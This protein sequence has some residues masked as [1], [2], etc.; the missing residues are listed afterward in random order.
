ME[1]GKPAYG[2]Y[3]PKSLPFITELSAAPLFSDGKVVGAVE[4]LRKT[5]QRERVLDFASSLIKCLSS[6]Q[7]LSAVCR[8]LHEGLKYDRVRLYSVGPEDKGLRGVMFAGNHPKVTEETFRT[9]VGRVPESVGTRWMNAGRAGLLRLGEK[10]PIR[11]SLGYWDCPLDK[12]EF[13]REVDPNDDLEFGDVKEIIVVPFEAEKDHYLFFVDSKYRGEGTGTF[14]HDDLQAVSMLAKLADAALVA[15]VS[16]R[17]RFIM[18]VV[19]EVTC[20]PIHELANLLQ[21]NQF[22]DDVILPFEK[23]LDIA[24][25][26][27]SRTGSPA[28]LACVWQTLD[29]AIRCLRAPGC[30]RATGSLELRRSVEPLTLKVV[31]LKEKY[32][33]ALAQLADLD[34]KMAEGW[35]VL[36]QTDKESS[37]WLEAFMAIRDIIV[38]FRTQANVSQNIGLLAEGIRSVMRSDSELEARQLERKN[39]VDLVKLAVETTKRHAVKHAVSVSF[40]GTVEPLWALLLGGPVVMAMLA[41]LDNAITA[42]GKTAS[43]SVDIGFAEDH[44]HVTVIIANNGNRIPLEHIPHVGK[45]PFTTKEPGQGTGLGLVFAYHWVEAS[46]GSIEHEF[47][48]L[49][50]LTRFAIRL[51]SGKSR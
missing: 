12:Q 7:V 42:A 43:G 5:T 48:E 30:F 23:L 47:D 9:R 18:A 28:E 38:G 26:R 14:S 10:G 32:A 3:Q 50:G 49:A 15:V 31:G 22:H 4:T 33:L 8:F 13:R 27:V 41:L 11:E 51:K 21:A 37:I 24:K 29:G 25:I 40:S 16:N 6:D 44:E 19:G 35:K 45:V 2:C 46:T 39:V 17:V 34:G 36:L 1:S 20:G